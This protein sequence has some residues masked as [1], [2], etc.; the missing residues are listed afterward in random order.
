M[1][2]KDGGNFQISRS[3]SGGYG[4]CFENEYCSRRFVILFVSVTGS[5]EIIKSHADLLK[6]LPVE[7]D[8]KALHLFTD[9]RQR[10][11]ENSME[12]KDFRASG[13]VLSSR[14]VKGMTSGRP[15]VR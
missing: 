4:T 15:W 11:K 5:Q 8:T 12:G 14:Y 9:S 13:G 10:V 6:N 1:T 7:R 2:R 3:S